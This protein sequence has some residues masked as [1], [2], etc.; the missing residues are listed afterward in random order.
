MQKKILLVDDQ[1]LDVALTRQALSDCNIEHKIV[2]ALD[3]LEGLAQL[4]SQ[5]F[6]VVVLDLKMPKV[7]GFE[8]LA[9]MRMQPS[10]SHLPVIVVSNSNLEI[11]RVRAATL[12][13]VEYIHKS[14]D[15]SEFR[16]NLKDALGRHGFC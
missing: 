9:Q 8:V 13:A 6:D 2:A 5:Q 12:G 16:T 11:D 4:Q 10:L 3:G 1:L 15:Y 14:L 7:D